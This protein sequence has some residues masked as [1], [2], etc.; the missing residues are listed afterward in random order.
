MVGGGLEAFD[1]VADTLQGF[2][3]VHAL[4]WTVLVPPL[5]G[6]RLR[7]NPPIYRRLDHAAVVVVVAFL[8]RWAALLLSSCFRLCVRAAAPFSCLLNKLRL[9]LLLLT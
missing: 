8:S 3:V 4:V 7:R 6:S 5:Q 1:I 9:W 2:K